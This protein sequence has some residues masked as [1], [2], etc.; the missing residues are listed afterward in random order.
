M[1][2]DN[3]RMDRKKANG[4]KLIILAGYKKQINQL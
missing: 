4:L 3:F 1:I 2:P